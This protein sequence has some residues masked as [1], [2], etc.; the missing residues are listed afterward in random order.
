[1]DKFLHELIIVISNKGYTDQ[2]MDTAKEKGARGGTIVHGKGTASDET[3]RFFGLEIQA[4]KEIILIVVPKD[5]T[6]E[7]MKAISFEHGV[8]TKARSLC[9]ALPISKLTGFTF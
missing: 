9:F 3:R 2:I 7:I 6:N 1:M 8:N 4:E 5:K